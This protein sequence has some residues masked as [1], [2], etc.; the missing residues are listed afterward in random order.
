MNTFL[1]WYTLPKAMKAATPCSLLL[2][3]SDE[4]HLSNQFWPNTATSSWYL[5]DVTIV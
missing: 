3:L 2:A 5:T 4:T 1:G